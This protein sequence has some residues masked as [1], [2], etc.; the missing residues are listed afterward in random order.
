MSQVHHSLSDKRFRLKSR[1]R[2]EAAHADRCRLGSAS[3]ASCSFHSSAASA[4]R[5]ARQPSTSPSRYRGRGAA[6]KADSSPEATPAASPTAAGSTAP[7]V[8]QAQR[9]DAVPIS[10]PGGGGGP[11]KHAAKAH[12]GGK[13][14]LPPEMMQARTVKQ[15]PVSPNLLAE[16]YKYGPPLS[17]MYT[18]EVSACPKGDDQSQL[19]ARVC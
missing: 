14:H 13:I 7:A 15:T 10:T 12:M 17:C 5:P 8:T 1:L 18:K 11:S 19:V 9:L 16:P 4:A 2:R 3:E 6:A